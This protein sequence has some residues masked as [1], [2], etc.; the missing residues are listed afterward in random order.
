MDCC[1]HA[2]GLNQLF[3][4]RTARE[5]AEHYWRHGIDRHARRLADALL[6]RGIAGASVLEV[7]G[8]IGGLHAELLRNGAARAIDVDIAAAYIAAAQ[9]VAERLGLRER[10][11]YHQADFASMADSLPAADVV[12]MHRVV[13]CYPDMPQLIGAAAQ[14]AERLLALSF[15]RAAWYSQLARQAM[16][17]MMRLQRSGYR[18]Y[19]HSPAAISA[20]AASHGL[21]PARLIRSWPWDIALFERA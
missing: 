11:E 1:S 12:V 2:K 21:R 20:V 19:V 18:F 3:D 15:P 6:A 4:E 8:G 14:H 9:G 5:D 13:C 17:G 10:I 16:N 7:G